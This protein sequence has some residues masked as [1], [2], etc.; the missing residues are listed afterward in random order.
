MTSRRPTVGDLPYGSIYTVAGT[1]TAG[2]SGDGAPAIQA[3]L[4]FPAG[5]TVN[6]PDLLI[7]DAG[8]NRIRQITG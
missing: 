3:D 5:L 1:G 7:A 8:N 6:G 2:F 4:N